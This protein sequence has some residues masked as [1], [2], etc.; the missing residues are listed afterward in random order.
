VTLESRPREIE[1]TSLPQGAELDSVRADA[2]RI[3]CDLE[4][5]D[6]VAPLPQ[7]RLQRARDATSRLAGMG[8]SMLDSS[9]LVGHWWALALRGAVAIIFGVLAFIWP[10]LTLAILVLFWGAYALVDGVLDVVAGLRTSHDH[11]W[12]LLIEGVIGIAAGVATFAWPGLTALV[13]VYIIAAWGV[14][15]GVFEVIAAIRLRQVIRNE[16]LLVLSGIVSVLFGIALFVA[17]GA[18]ALAL[19]WLIAAFAI[20]DGILLLLLAVRLRGLAREQPPSLSRVG[21]TPGPA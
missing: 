21:P 10:G 13:L 11:R 20:V 7:V 17:P 2:E 1:K 12:G 3:D 9:G 4:D 16:W 15:T 18:G 8:R 19:V 14:V 6:D 5:K